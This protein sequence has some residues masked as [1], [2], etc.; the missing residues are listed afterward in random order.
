MTNFTNKIIKKLADK[1]CNLTGY[2]QQLHPN[3]IIPDI[4]KAFDDNKC[5][6]NF[7]PANP[8]TDELVCLKCGLIINSSE[9]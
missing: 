6:H 8:L 7:A 2:G 5:E 3:D 1:I 9:K 4:Q